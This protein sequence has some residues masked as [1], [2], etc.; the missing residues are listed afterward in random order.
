MMGRNDFLDVS[1]GKL[2]NLDII[3]FTVYSLARK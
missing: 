1:K 2:L 3:I